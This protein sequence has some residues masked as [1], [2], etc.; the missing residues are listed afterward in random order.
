M[1]F[2]SPVSSVRIEEYVE[3]P[4]YPNQVKENLLIAVTNKSNMKCPQPYEQVSRLI[5]DSA[6]AHGGGRRMAAARTDADGG[7]RAWRRLLDVAS[8]SLGLSR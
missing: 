8:S 1:L 2:R 6:E 5:L 4:P 7:R 3:A